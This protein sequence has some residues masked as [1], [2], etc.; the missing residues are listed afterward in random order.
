MYHSF[1]LTVSINAIG[2]FYFTELI[3]AIT[4]KWRDSARKWKQISTPPNERKRFDYAKFYGFPMNLLWSLKIRWQIALFS[5][6]KRIRWKEK[7]KLLWLVLWGILIKLNKTC[8]YGIWFMDCQRKEKD[9]RI[10]EQT[11]FSSSSQCLLRHG[12]MSSPK[13]HVHNLRTYTMRLMKSRCCY[14][15]VYRNL[16][17]SNS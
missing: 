2:T 16:F 6:R 7:K 1:Y 8:C 5:N 17:D 3:S 10:Y 11:H 4:R 14:N 9:R 12:I 15:K 13:P